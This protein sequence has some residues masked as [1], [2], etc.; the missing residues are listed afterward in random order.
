MDGIL[1]FL[2]G[3]ICG[4]TVAVFVMAMMSMTGEDE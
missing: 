2:W 3:C 4:A 1:I